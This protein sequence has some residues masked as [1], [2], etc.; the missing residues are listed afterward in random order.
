MNNGHKMAYP[1]PR[2]IEEMT[3]HTGLTKREY[4]SALAP[5]QIPHWFKID[6]KIKKPQ[7]PKSWAEFPEDDPHREELRKWQHDPIYDLPE[8]LQWYQKLWQKYH[9]QMH[10]Y[11]RLIQAERYFAWRKY[12]ADEL[13]KQ[14]EQF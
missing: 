3:P 8:E 6:S 5:N 10:E 2:P 12:Y 11:D 14:L 13:L 9:D 7:S 1:S 4:F